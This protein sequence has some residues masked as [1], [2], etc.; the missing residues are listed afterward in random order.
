MPSE[1]TFVTTTS[2]IGF[3][4]YLYLL[5]HVA[6]PIVATY[7]FVNPVVAMALGWSVGGESLGPRTLTAAAVV[8]AAVVLITTARPTPRGVSAPAG[9]GAV[10]VRRA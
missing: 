6:P 9:A 4:A 7:A 5:R 3:G 10:P 1:F 2:V 8:L